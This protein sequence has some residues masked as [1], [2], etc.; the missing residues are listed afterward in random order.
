MA[1]FRSSALYYTGV[2]C[3][4]VATVLRTL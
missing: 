2:K 4:P 3:V 1:A